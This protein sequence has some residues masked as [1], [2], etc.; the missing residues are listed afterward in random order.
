MDKIGQY[1]ESSEESSSEQTLPVT[2][3]SILSPSVAW[4]SKVFSD[5][6]QA[7]PLPKKVATN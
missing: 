1:D 5:E 6:T 4:P 7:I 2:R 3:V